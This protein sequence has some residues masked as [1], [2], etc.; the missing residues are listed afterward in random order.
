MNDSSASSLTL[1]PVTNISELHPGDL[2][3]VYAIDRCV[4]EL[5]EAYKDRCTIF[6]P[7]VIREK[8]ITI[9]SKL[10]KQNNF[11]GIRLKIFVEY[12]Y[13]SKQYGRLQM[14]DSVTGNYHSM[15]RRYVYYLTDFKEQRISGMH[16][17]FKIIEHDF[18]NK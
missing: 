10:F 9:S 17:F 15:Y 2:V 14:I 4:W 13:T 18:R 16:V 1:V 5:S 12:Q 11:S 6:Y 7:A 8:K 3:F